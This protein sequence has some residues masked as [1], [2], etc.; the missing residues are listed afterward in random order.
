MITFEA[1]KARYEAGRISLAMLRIYVKK[2]IITQAQYE[3]IV[4]G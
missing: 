2:G 1:L 3:E 4:N